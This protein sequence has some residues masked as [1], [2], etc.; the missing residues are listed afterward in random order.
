VLLTDETTASDLIKIGWLWGRLGRDHIL[1]LVK[2]EIEL[3]SDL[4]VL[5]HYRFAKEA[6]EVSG[7]IRDFFDARERRTAR[8]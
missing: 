8:P 1:L 2:D 6:A 3:P 7:K 4:Q 5:E